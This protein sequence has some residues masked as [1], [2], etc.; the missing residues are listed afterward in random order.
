[1]TSYYDEDEED[2]VP[3]VDYACI[4]KV[5]QVREMAK[6]VYIFYKQLI[7]EGFGPEQAFELTVEFIDT[8]E[9]RSY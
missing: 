6:L 9:P 5:D 7:D 1:M 2:E 3:E 8:I 4:Q